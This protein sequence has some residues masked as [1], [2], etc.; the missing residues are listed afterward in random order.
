MAGYIQLLLEQVERKLSKKTFWSKSDANE[1]DNNVLVLVLADGAG[2]QVSQ[3]GESSVISLSLIIINSKLLS[4]D[5]TSTQSHNILTILQ[6]AGAEKSELCCTFF[7]PLLK[8]IT[9]FK[10]SDLPVQYLHLV[11]EF[12]LLNDG[13]MMYALTQHSL[14]KRKGYP[15][16]QCTCCREGNIDQL[17]TM[18]DRDLYGK[19]YR[20]SEK[21]L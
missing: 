11:F 14:F 19:A 18:L 15:H 20:R 4:Y 13:K 5:Y 16:M 2:H 12:E 10:S 3:D 8:E 6:I 21:H 1:F 17:C 9:S 7:L